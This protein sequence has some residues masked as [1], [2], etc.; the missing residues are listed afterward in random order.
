MEASLTKSGCMPSFPKIFTIGQ[1]YIS[2]LFDEPVEVTEKVDGSQFGFGWVGGEFYVR[3]KGQVLTEGNVPGMF[4]MGWEYAHS[5]STLIPPDTFMYGEFLN[6][7][8]HNNLT[9]GRT[10]KNNVA[11]FGVFAEGE[12][13]PYDTIAHWAGVIECD[14][15]PRLYEGS[16]GIVDDLFEILDRDS[17]LGGTHIEGIVCKR[18]T[19]WLLG[20]QPQPLMAGKFVSEKY[21]EKARGWGKEN[22]GKG[23][24]TTYR[25]E[26]RTEAR[27]N[28]AIQH[29]RESGLITDSP[30]DIGP[31]IKE[32]KRDILEE[33]K[34]DI[35]EALWGF[36]GEELLRSSI[37]G[38][39]EWYKET[40]MREVFSEEGSGED[41]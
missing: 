35:K 39:P 28:K 19:P 40:L 17:F 37:V 34:E 1:R 30:K 20:D 21:K 4:E 3:S 27:W 41:N 12:P 9:Y 16:I 7:P 11:L 29:L 38:L 23:Q 2:K 6:K 24:W 31:L 13:Q 32:V 8:K 25:D 5:V 22:T 33:C 15:V 36:F 26:Y 14:V 18:Y 10:P